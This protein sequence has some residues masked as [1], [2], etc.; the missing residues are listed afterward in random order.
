MND[1]LGLCE[2]NPKLAGQLLKFATHVDL[3]NI[4]YNP[5]PKKGIK[6]LLVGYLPVFHGDF[7][8][9]LQI[10]FEGH[11]MQQDWNELMLSYASDL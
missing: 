10:H 5:N 1:S 4:D 11:R 3:K 6:I 8:P 2:Q 7:P 9:S